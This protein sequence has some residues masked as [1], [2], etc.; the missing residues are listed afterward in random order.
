MKSNWDEE[1][2]TR[3]DSDAIGEQY[4]NEKLRFLQQYEKV[5]HILES[6]EGA[7]PASIKL[8]AITAL[9]QAKDNWRPFLAGDVF[10]MERCRLL[11]GQNDPETIIEPIEKQMKIIVEGAGQFY[12]LGLIRSDKFVESEMLKYISGYEVAAEA[13]FKVLFKR[14]ETA[15]KSI[16]KDANEATSK[17]PSGK[18]F[19][20]EN[21]NILRMVVD[22]LN[23]LA[24]E[25]H[26][27][28]SQ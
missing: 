18:G 6:T 10:S 20:A 16:V 24:A 13:R 8:S 9:D 5:L 2:G 1:S 27:S 14:E 3:V 7:N 4:E 28:H 11:L 12:P 15:L 21:Y 17:Y 22:S 25:L 23:D 19:D 26:I